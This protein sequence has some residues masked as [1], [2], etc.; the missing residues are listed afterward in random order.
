MMHI[1]PPIG[2]QPLTAD[3]KL[4]AINK[5]RADK[6]LREVH[7][8]PPAQIT[9]S[10]AVLTVGRGNYLAFRGSFS[11][12]LGSQHLLLLARDDAISVTFA[13]VVGKTYLLDV[14]STCQNWIYTLFNGGVA[15]APTPITA[16]QNHV[17][18]PFIATGG[19]INLTL[20]IAPAE[21]PGMKQFC[22]A[23]LTRID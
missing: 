22:S 2:R 23:E 7:S 11:G 20:S 19:N 17:L 15:S 9:L 12:Q 6:K 13:T 10:P 16:Q 5:F 8:V 18:L 4:K 14:H 21:R 1:A 3:I